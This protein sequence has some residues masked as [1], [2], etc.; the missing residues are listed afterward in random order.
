MPPRRRVVGIRTYVGLP[1][2]LKQYSNCP[3]QVDMERLADGLQKLTEDDLLQV[4]EMIH[5]HKSDNTFTKN[6]VESMYN[7]MS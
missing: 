1:P 4:V 2:V 6:D 5:T 3:H 7:D